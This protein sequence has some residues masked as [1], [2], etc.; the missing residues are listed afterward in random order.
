MPSGIKNNG[1]FARP[2]TS[3]TSLPAISGQ[4][5]AP[6]TALSSAFRHV[7]GG[8]GAQGHLP[9]APLKTGQEIA[10]RAKAEKPG[11]AQTGA[12]RKTHIG[13]RSGHK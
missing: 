8:T 7:L 4:P 3:A 12:P 11:A 9:T 5:A 1:P 13:P 10:R 2:E 6:D